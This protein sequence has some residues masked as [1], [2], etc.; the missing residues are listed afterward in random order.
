MVEKGK[1]KHAKGQA[2]LLNGTK[3]LTRESH[4]DGS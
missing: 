1:G 4:Q 2:R 3:E